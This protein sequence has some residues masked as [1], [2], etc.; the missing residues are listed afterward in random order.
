VI[1]KLCPSRCGCASPTTGTTS[2]AVAKNP[3][4]CSDWVMRKK[5][6]RDDLGNLPC[7]DTLES[8]VFLLWLQGTGDARSASGGLLADEAPASFER[9]GCN[10]VAHIDVGEGRT[11][12]ME[13]S[14]PAI[15]PA[16]CG[17]DENATWSSAHAWRVDYC[18]RACGRRQPTSCLT[19][20]RKHI[21]DTGVY[22]PFAGF[23]CIFPFDYKGKTYNH[24]TTGKTDNN[25][26]SFDCIVPWCAVTLKKGRVFQWGTC[27]PGC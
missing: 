15:C 17:C 20:S 19:V 16:S 7:S 4:G 8:D 9:G 27:P 6:F 24:C 10:A 11:L 26:T 13:S 5:R 23:P 2:S 14:L 21:V 25:C 22:G 12:C 18:P 3:Q 1:R